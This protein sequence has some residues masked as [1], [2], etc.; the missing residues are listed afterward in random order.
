MSHD[1]IWVLTD[2]DYESKNARIADL[3]SQIAE[4]TAERERGREIA[5]AYYVVPRETLEAKDARIKELESR[6]D[7]DEHASA[8]LI[9]TLEVGQYQHEIAALKAKVKDL[10]STLHET[11]AASIKASRLE[12]RLSCEEGKYDKCGVGGISV[13]GAIKAALL[14]EQMLDSGFRLSYAAAC[15]LVLHRELEDVKSDAFINEVRSMSRLFS[16]LD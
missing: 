10:E 3:E 5:G 7:S 8:Y 11:R 15:L 16:T 1:D 9:Q 6:L 13:D 12:K 4:L 2:E 14:A